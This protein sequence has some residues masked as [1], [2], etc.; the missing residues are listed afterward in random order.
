MK[1]DPTEARRVAEEH[2]AKREAATKG[3]WWVTGAPWGDGQSVHAGPS[4]DPYYAI[5][6]R[7]AHE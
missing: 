6:N 2:S 1:F 7:E 4:D 5:L 3:S